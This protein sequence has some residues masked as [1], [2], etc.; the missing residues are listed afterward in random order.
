MNVLFHL[1]SAIGL[2]VLLT[3]T[4][5]LTQS[6]KVSP[7]LV[8]GILGFFA[9][10]ISHGALDYIPHCY[11]VNS[12]ADAVTGLLLMLFL[13]VKTNKKFRFITVA[14]LLGSVFPDL[15][16]L[17]PAILNKQVDLNLPIFEKV[18]PWH[19]KEYSGSVYQNSCDISTL[20]HLLLFTTIIII[21][22]CRRA[23]LQ[24]MIKGTRQVNS[25]N[26]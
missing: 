18:F 7:V 5:S 20:N 3:D 16:D 6:Q 2:T 9:G 8:T 21:G 10:I 23:D 19:W 26:S 12:K 22:W 11:P 15:V 14:T 13:T 4:K 17:A 25:S 24:V 1:T